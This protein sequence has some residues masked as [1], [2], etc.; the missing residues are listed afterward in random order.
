MVRS[1]PLNSMQIK[2]PNLKI[3]FVFVFIA[4]LICGMLLG[5]S[6]LAPSRLALVQEHMLGVLHGGIVDQQEDV[7][8]D[9]CAR[10]SDV[11]GP[12]A[13]TRTTRTTVFGDGT[14]LTVMF[15]SPPT[16]TNVQCNG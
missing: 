11:D 9:G 8:V 16:P 15:T 7:Y 1:S 4:I 3:F 6:F 12:Q 14:I 13:V 10:I 2:T 5:I